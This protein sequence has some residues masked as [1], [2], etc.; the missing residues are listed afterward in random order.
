M[1]VN[2]SAKLKLKSYT[3]VLAAV[4]NTIKSFFY[5]NKSDHR[6][7]TVSIYTIQVWFSSNMK[8]DLFL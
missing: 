7:Y 8:A 2:L 6:L 5:I 3:N 4:V 1:Q